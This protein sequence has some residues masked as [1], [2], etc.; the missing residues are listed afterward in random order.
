MAPEL[1]ILILLYILFVLLLVVFLPK[2]RSE[3]MVEF[4]FGI[5]DRLPWAVICK[6][7]ANK[8]PDRRAKK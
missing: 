5:L 3:R 7:F 1:L 4:I 2:E 6:V 8:K